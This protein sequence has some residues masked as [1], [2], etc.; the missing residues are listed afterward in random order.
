MPSEEYPDIFGAVFGHW[1][2]DMSAIMRPDQHVYYRGYMPG[3]ADCGAA[4]SVALGPVD[5]PPPVPAMW[6]WEKIPLY[7]ARARAQIEAFNSPS[8]TYLPFE[9]PS[10]MRQDGRTPCVK[11]EH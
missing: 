2:Q 9:K 7:N 1:L 11:L 8:F 5:P 4:V 3:H 10:Y 6:S